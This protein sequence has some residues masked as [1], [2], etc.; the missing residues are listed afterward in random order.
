MTPTIQR[1]F[2]TNG[3]G[4]SVTQQSLG[5]PPAVFPAAVATDSDMIIAVDR[6]QTRLALPMSATDSSI[7]VINPSVIAAY[8][9]LTI[10]LETVKVTGPPVGNVVPV[11]RAFDGSTAA[12][13]LAS[14]VVSGFVDAYH[15]NRLVAEVEA[16]EQALGPNLSR[17]PAL[18]FVI[19]T[20]FIF[21][22]QTPGGSLVAGNNSITLTP[23]PPGVNGTDLGHTLYI[24]G[25]TGAAEAALITG[26]SAVAGAPS[27]TLI[28]NC[29]NA[30]SGA[31]TIQSATAG[32]QEAIASLGGAG[33]VFVP[34][35]S[36]TIYST[37]SITHNAVWLAGMGRLAS[38][39]QWA[40]PTTGDVVFFNGTGSSGGNG[41]SSGIRDI[42]ING[43]GT[44]GSS[45][46]AVRVD[47][48][49]NFIMRGVMMGGFAGG[50]HI[51][52]TGADYQN[53]YSD[54]TIYVMHNGGGCGV[55]IDNGGGCFMNIAIGGD[56]GQAASNTVGFQV[57]STGG[58]WMTS[59]Q[60]LFVG[61][62]LV[63]N[64]GSGQDVKFMWVT[65]CCFDTSTNSAAG[66]ANINIS[67]SGTGRAFSI[68]FDNC[69][70]SNGAQDGIVVGSGG[71][72]DGIT[73]IG[74]RSVLNG[75]NGCTVY[76]GSNIIFDHCTMTQNSA[77][78]SGHAIGLVIAGTGTNVQVH[79]G[80]YGTMYGGANSQAYGILYEGYGDYHS[81]IA[82]NVRN[83]VTGGLSLA[84]SPGTH[85]V[86][87]DNIGYNPVGQFTITVGAS[88]FTYK[89]GSSPETVYISGGTV[90]GVNIGSTQVAWATN[91]SLALGPNQT[92][93]VIYTVTPT[94]V[95]DIQ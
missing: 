36:F 73:F 68:N 54:V 74:F 94:M 4:G 76:G 35:G 26:G 1:T 20:N 88:P 63:I 6:Q 53:T 17:I 81:I 2:R 30:H 83:N 42:Q 12:V 21:P 92:I 3:F 72:I 90:Q 78:T 57:Q 69:W 39:L 7:T 46:Y 84:T 95:R 38:N 89:T 11:S 33:T 85:S 32:I 52:S 91:V 47:Q 82:A 64:P 16:I 59:C 49:A 79:G 65:D 43:P 28:V 45:N 31:W 50:I 9:L 58:I 13:H 37:I 66:A 62:G 93:T 77:T 24:S 75:N 61:Q 70:A 23:V 60:T 19:S 25:G 15:H 10:D 41:S 29:A 34:N 44:V 86:I 55:R 40:G 67:P 71:T 80:T 14:A 22:A 27:G 5:K 51:T 8:S 18:A 87:K 48:Q 56:A